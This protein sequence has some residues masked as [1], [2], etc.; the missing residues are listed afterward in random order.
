MLEVPS[1]E[2]ANIDSNK[3]VNEYKNRAYSQ[4]YPK[5]YY[6]FFN[7]FRSDCCIDYGSLARFARHPF[8]L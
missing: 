3:F 6:Y 7:S 8:Y 2:S 1:G 4:S 5:N